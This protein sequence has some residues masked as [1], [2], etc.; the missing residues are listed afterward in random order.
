M[1]R[2]K[3]DTQRDWVPNNVCVYASARLLL[4]LGSSL[5]W[6]FLCAFRKS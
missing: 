3:A 2:G 6:C 1:V 5:T 4:P